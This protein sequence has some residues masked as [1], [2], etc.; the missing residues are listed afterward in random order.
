M[1]DKLDKSSLDY[2]DKFFPSEL[3]AGFE[4][5]RKHGTL[6]D[7]VLRVQDEEFHC[8]R[9]LLAVSSPYFRAMFTGGMLESS[10]NNVTIH[11]IESN[12]MKT[13]LDYIYSGRVSITMNTSQQLLDAASLFQFP[14]LIEACASFLQ[15]ELQP[16]NCINVYHLAELYGCSTLAEVARN[17][18]LR[19]FIDVTH[20]SEFLQLSVDQLRCFLQD[21]QLVYAGID[22]LIRAIK[23]WIEY[24]ETRSN[25]T[26]ELLEMWKEPSQVLNEIQHSTNVN[27]LSNY[28]VML[29]FGD[30]WE[31]P[32]KS[33][34]KCPVK[35]YD[36]VRKV[37]YALESVPN[38][39]AARDYMNA[40]AVDDA[41]VVGMRTGKFMVYYPSSG[42]WEMV[43][44]YL[45]T[46]LFGN[47]IVAMGNNVYIS[48]RDGH[49]FCYNMETKK[50]VSKADL[51]SPVRNCC[52]IT[53]GG[54]VYVLGGNTSGDLYATGVDLVQCYNPVNDK[55]QLCSPLPEKCTN[56]AAVVL[57]GLIYVIGANC[58][59]HSESTNR[60]YRYNQTTDS[61]CRIA[62]FTIPRQCFG[63]VVCNGKIYITGGVDVIG[64]Q[65][66]H[67]IPVQEVECYDPV[68][69][70]WSI[71]DT[72]SI[73]IANHTCIALPWSKTN[74]ELGLGSEE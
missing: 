11:N 68:T 33:L 15:G 52:M 10:A 39:V 47:T 43:A 29:L 35:C 56:C 67:E 70:E 53:L 14:R 3:L 40:A 72:L 24:D 31:I 42:K 9:T 74:P 37:F 4:E 51:L 73:S 17:F 62:D 30:Y 58:R 27:K 41:V 63:A 46:P 60:V 1:E 50:L 23:T 65:S 44:K 12:T 32:G 22:N 21:D 36:P 54:R 5:L 71:V 26:K 69:D 64:N 18:T 19:H 25:Y 2:L 48:G 16:S 7:V 20:Y 8:H 59:E 49:F 55:W 34:S 28:E 66:Q 6:T 45:V 57:N 61:W 13:V 38:T